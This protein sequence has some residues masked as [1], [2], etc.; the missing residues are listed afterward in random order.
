MVRVPGED[1][2]VF[3]A[4][5]QAHARMHRAVPL[6]FSPRVAIRW[7]QGGADVTFTVPRAQ[8]AGFDSWFATLPPSMI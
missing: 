7:R 6:F 3:A 8:R 4:I 1:R 2:E 5:G